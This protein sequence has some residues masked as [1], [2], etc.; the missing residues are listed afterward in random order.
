MVTYGARM[1]EFQDLTKTYGR[2]RAVEGL[3]LRVEPGEVY[4][5]LGPNGAGKTTA[6]RC[7]ATLQ[8]PT[9]GTAFV[10]DA[11]VRK[12]P[13]VARAR[14][15]FLAASMGLYERLTPVELLQYFGRLHR[16]EG[17]ALDRRVAQLVQVFGIAPFVSQRCGTLSTGAGATRLRGPSTYPRSAR[18]HSR[19]AD[20]GTRRAQWRGDLSVH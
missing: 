12:Q 17:P 10:G 8:V 15:G 5:L 6:L 3:S 1:I 4:A 14:I 13:L 19:R 16:M 2:L 9:S 11:D 18:P 7:L 20:D